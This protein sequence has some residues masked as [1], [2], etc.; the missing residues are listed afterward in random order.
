MLALN[1]GYVTGSVSSFG[2]NLLPVMR[3][4]AVQGENVDSVKVLL[5]AKIYLS[6]MGGKWKL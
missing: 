6:F 3:Y 1:N 2:N 4:G 5:P